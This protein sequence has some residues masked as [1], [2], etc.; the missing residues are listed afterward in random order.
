MPSTV[1]EMTKAG[2]AEFKKVWDS[3]NQFEHPRTPNRLVRYFYA[4]FD[5]YVG[6]IDRY[7]NSVIDAPTEEQYEYLVEHYVGA[8][9]LEEADIRLGAREYLLKRANYWKAQTSRK[10]YA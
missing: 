4:A 6:F 9:D 7:G 8:G 5:G 3:A 1:N 10:K 2:G